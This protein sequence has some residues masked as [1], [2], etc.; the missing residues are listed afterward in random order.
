MYVLIGHRSVVLTHFDLRKSLDNQV[1]SNRCG[2]VVA[3]A[4]AVVGE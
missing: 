2:Q 4:D 3:E 1:V